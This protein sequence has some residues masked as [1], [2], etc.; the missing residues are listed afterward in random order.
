MGVGESLPYDE[1]L[2][3][4]DGKYIYR[5]KIGRIVEEKLGVQVVTFDSDGRVIFSKITGH[6]KH[7]LN[8]KMLEV[9]TKTGRRIKVTDKHS[10]FSLVGSEIESV[11]TKNLVA[12]ESVIAIPS[13]IPNVSTAFSELNL[14]EHFRDR[15]GYMLSNVAGNLKLAKKQYGLDKVSLALGVSKKYIADII[16]KNLSVDAGKFSELIDKTGF[17]P[18]FSKIT[19]GV[20]GARSHLPIFF[21]VDADLC[22]ILGLFVAEGDFNGD[23]VRITNANPEIRQDTLTILQTLGLGVT[24]TET[25]II[26]NSCIFKHV[27]DKVFGLKTGAFNKRIPGFLFAASNIQVQNFLKGY[28]SGDGS[29]TRSERRYVIEASTVSKNLANDLLYLFLKM[30][31][32]AGCREK[33]EWNGTMSYGVQVFGVENFRKFMAIGFI[34]SRRNILVGSYIEEKAWS[35]S[36][37]IPV[38]YKITEVLES[39]F[40]SYPKNHS[41]GVRKLRE[42]LCVVDI[43]KEKYSSLWKLVEADIYWDKVKEINEVN[44]SGDVYDISVDPC[45]NFVAGFGGI[46]AHNSEKGIRKIFQRA[47]QVSPVI[48]FFDEFDAISSRRGSGDGSGVGERMVNQLL[49]E[50]DGVEELKGVV[51]VAATNRPDL[52]DPALMRPG[53]IDKIIH[54]PA[55]DLG[56]RKV[57]LEIHTKDTPLASNI[58]LNEIAQ[59]TEGYS[60]ADIEGLIREA[61][62]LS[63]KESNFKSKE[64][65]LSHLEE[66]LNKTTP[67]ITQETIEAYKAFKSQATQAFKPSYVR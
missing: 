21:K 20:K 3:V 29:I 22:R 28:F 39:A 48:I 14:F 49:T 59:K 18:D 7:P 26:V 27:L 45:Q 11:A 1:E 17:K 16:C 41:V 52:I 56:A 30:G 35:R 63:M 34:D 55:P 10:L 8:G 62:L 50:L 60:G 38:N 64:I 66:A 43:Q 58:D 44:Y 32:V 33:L 9:K 57:I 19:I 2:L 46:F 37:V 65:K 51:F 42:A 12:G 31:I 6:I 5:E 23:I 36:N 40:G 13:R 24:K 15:K 61:A 67:S 54:I 53:R 4:F 25:N 47:R